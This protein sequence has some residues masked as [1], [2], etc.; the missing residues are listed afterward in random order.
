MKFENEQTFEE[1][2]EEPSG[3]AWRLKN[4]RAWHTEGTKRSGFGG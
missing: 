3:M 1:L 2:E 4:K